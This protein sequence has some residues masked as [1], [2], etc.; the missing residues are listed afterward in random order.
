MTVRELL[1]RI[2]SRELSEWIAYYELEPWGEER[3]DLR[4]GIVAATVVNSR[5]RDKR[6]PGKT[7]KPEDFMPKFGE[8]KQEQTWQDHLAMLGSLQKVFGGTITKK[9]GT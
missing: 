6:N 8:T 1:E 3:A 2:D 5:P 9:R 7:Y 4:A